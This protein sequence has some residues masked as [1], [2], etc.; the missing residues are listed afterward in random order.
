MA[1]T[2]SKTKSSTEKLNFYL[3]LGI[4]AFLL[5]SAIVHYATPVYQARRA[6]NQAEN[7][8]Q[9]GLGSVAADTIDPFRHQ[10]V[11]QERSC[12]ILLKAYYQVKNA[13]RL[14]WTAQS[15]LDAGVDIPEVYL[16]WAAARELF[17]HDNE[18]VQILT[19]AAQ[20]FDRAP[21][22]FYELAQIYR[23]NKQDEVA[24][25]A[26]FRAMERDPGDQ[27]L[28][29]NV[30]AYCMDL[31]RYEDAKK[32]AEKVKTLST[33]N[34]EVKLMIARAFIKGGEPKSAEPLVE[35]ARAI[36]ATKDDA[37]KKR[38]QQAYSD[39]LSK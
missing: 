2:S 38:V 31:K 34:F 16:G 12:R 28:A 26:Y 25:E 14:E 20:K 3:L 4:V 15:C 37:T 24:V 35:S 5:L 17:N 21:A 6:L 22:V 13:D 33:D 18:A 29:V 11:A 19:G 30:L 36:L 1:E 8:L 27:Q 32:I 10:Y 9:K 7:Q 23:R 39:V